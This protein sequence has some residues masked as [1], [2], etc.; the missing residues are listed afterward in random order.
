MNKRYYITKYIKSILLKDL[1]YFERFSYFKYIKNLKI[2]E[3]NILIEPQQGRTIDGNMF[4]IIKELTSKKEYN[5]YNIYVALKKDV[6]RRAKK[7]LNKNLI[8]NVTIVKFLS[9][10]YYRLL[11]ESKYLI[12]DTSFYPFFIKREGQVILNTWHGTPLKCLGKR[13]KN[14]YHRIGNVQKNFI[15]SD[16]LLYQNEYTRKNMI[17]SFML[18]NICDA[19]T[20]LAGYPRN[21]IFFDEN[22]RNKIKKELNLQYKEILVYM[23][24]WRENE[25]KKNIF[26]NKTYLLDELIEIENN[27]KENQILYV[28]IH[29]LER[30]NINFKAFKKI[31][32]FPQEYETYQFLNI[33][34]CLITDYSSV[35]FDFAVTRKKIILF[36]YDEEEYLEKRGLYLDFN[37][38][39]FTKVRNVNELINAINLDKQYDESE[40]INTYCKYDNILAAKKICEKIILNKDSDLIVKDIEN[41]GKDNVLIYTGNLAKNG[42]TSSLKNVL[43]N[44]DLNEKNYFL[45]F[46]SSVIRFNKEQLLDFPEGVNYISTV[47]KTN[48]SLL[49]KIKLILYRIDILPLKMFEKTINKVYKDEIKRLYGNIKFETVIQFGGYEYKKI[50]FYSQF[51][52]N[53]VI[54]VHS[55]MES[56]IKTR[57]TQHRNTLQYAYNTYNK[58]AIVNKDL[59]ETTI[60][61]SNRKDNIFVTNNIINYKDVI[62]K[63]KAPEIVFDENTV[64]NKSIDEIN[65]ILNGKNKVFITIGRFSPEKGHPRLIKAFNE[66]Y[67][68]EKDIYLIIIGGTGKQYNS[69]LE[70]INSLPCSEHIIVIKSISNPYVILKKC[71]Y[72]VLSSYY[73]GFGLVIAE[74]DILGKPVISTDI[75]GPRDFIKKNNGVL[76]ENSQEGLYEGMQKLLRGEIPVMHADYEEHNK[77][78]ISDFYKLL[79]E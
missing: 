26:K 66:I 7:V 19:K 25:H 4:Y 18:N 6:I 77:K 48:M 22:S 41:N 68:K 43:N 56:E 29:P 2:K 35:F 5:E 74:A 16:Y 28:N 47:G 67:K 79:N 31:K 65:E 21:T 50:L 15:V 64:S 44:I 70:L 60:K 42:I 75:T 38:L 36:C 12:T 8:N 57:Q 27:L 23:P 13:D 51:D 1:A 17:D 58:V 30:K 3:K 59:L 40:F 34:D 10:E 69:T 52:C 14:N 49:E 62:E 20:I 73:E 71:D 72:F 46:S 32:P 61:I 55:D 33:A 37:K 24:T 63:S 11:A 54:Y 39:P 53:T 45:T 76:V 9:K 78:A